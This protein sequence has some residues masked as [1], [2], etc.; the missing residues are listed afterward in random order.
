MISLPYIYDLDS[1]DGGKI[2]GSGDPTDSS[3]ALTIAHYGTGIGVNFASLA[4]TSI[5][6]NTVGSPAVRFR[7]AVT[8]GNALFVGR[9]VVA[10]PTVAPLVISQL[11]AAS[12]PAIEF[13]GRAFVSALSGGTVNGA[14]R[15][16]VGNDYFFIPTMRD[17]GGLGA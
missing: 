11:S 8:E 6:V 12:A 16:K 15:I 3:P 17:M 2:I 5:D 1:E 14:I 4:T 13:Q 7:S 10:S 9:S